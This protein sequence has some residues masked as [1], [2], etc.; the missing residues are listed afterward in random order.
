MSD[1]ELKK[2]LCEKLKEFN[3]FKH[4]VRTDYSS[5]SNSCVIF[6][7]VTYEKLHVCIVQITPFFYVIAY[8]NTLTNKQWTD[9]TRN[10][11]D[12]PKLVSDVLKNL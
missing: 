6:A 5:S 7:D 8:E 1:L 2:S 10:I 11:F 9:H 3:S 12:L 4:C